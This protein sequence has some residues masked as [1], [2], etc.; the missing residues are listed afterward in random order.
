MNLLS[1]TTVNLLSL[2]PAQ[3]L[4]GDKIHLGGDW[5][6]VDNTRAAD[7]IADNR[8][9]FVVVFTSDDDGGWYEDFINVD[10]KLAVA[11]QS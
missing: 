6:T 7:V 9:S 4:S 1:L 5:V 3:L 2:T 8:V 10:R 11:R